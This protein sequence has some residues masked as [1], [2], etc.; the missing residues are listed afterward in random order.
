MQMLG[1]PAKGVVGSLPQHLTRRVEATRPSGDAADVGPA[2]AWSCV[3]AEAATIQFDDKASV[4]VSPIEDHYSST[5]LWEIRRCS[6]LIGRQIASREACAL[7]HWLNDV[8]R[9]AH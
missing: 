5:A 3:N 7:G 6:H 1:T 9:F 2:L 4:C 8:L